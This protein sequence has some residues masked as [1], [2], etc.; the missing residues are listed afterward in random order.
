VICWGVSCVQQNPVCLGF[1]YNCLGSIYDIN[2]IFF[3][4]GGARPTLA[5]IQLRQWQLAMM[6]SSPSQRPRAA[7]RH[8]PPRGR[9]RA[10]RRRV[11]RALPGLLR[12]A[13]AA[14]VVLRHARLLSLP[15]ELNYGTFA[16]GWR[17]AAAGAGDG[18][19]AQGV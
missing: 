13:A 19:V 4:Q 17:T 11:H 8:S 7:A 15:T 16:S 14:A 2:V 10:L 1:F 6:I 3:G 5:T 18:T 9:G 12:S